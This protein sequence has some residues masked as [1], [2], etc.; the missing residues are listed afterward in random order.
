MICKR[1]GSECPERPEGLCF[2]CIV[3]IA[4]EKG[5]SE[6]AGHPVILLQ[7]GVVEGF[8][9][10]TAP[11][12]QAMMRDGGSLTDV[13][14]RDSERPQLEKQAGLFQWQKDQENLKKL[15]DAGGP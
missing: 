11:T 2:H 14:A 10:W 9:D 13:P 15:K 1:C 8:P 4:L 12:R 6:K 3:A 7:A 5:L